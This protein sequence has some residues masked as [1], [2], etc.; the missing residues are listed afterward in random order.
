VIGSSR[1]SDPKGAQNLAV[2][3]ILPV[4][5]V[6]AVQLVGV[7][8]LVPTMLFFLS[9]AVAILDIVILITAVNL[10]QRESIIVKW[11]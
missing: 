1:A 5:A 4:L 8:V 6:V 9:A 10:F 2:V 3:I 7:T 11:K